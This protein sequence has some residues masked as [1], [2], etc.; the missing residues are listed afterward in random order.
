MRKVEFAPD[1][2]EKKA[3]ET[4]S[5]SDYNFFV[6]ENG[7]YYGSIGNGEEFQLGSLKDVESFLM[8]G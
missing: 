6:D 2:L 8:E 1:Q 4:Y 7:I 3:F 5:D